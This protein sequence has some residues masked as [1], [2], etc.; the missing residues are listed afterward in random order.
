MCDTVVNTSAQCV[1][2]RSMQYLHIQLDIFPIRINSLP[3]VDTSLARLVVDVKVL[4]VVVEINTS[5]TQVSSEEGSV[6]GEDGRDVDVP[7]PAEGNG[8]T[9]LPF[10]EVGHDC[11][12]G[13]SASELR[14]SALVHI[15]VSE[16]GGSLTSPRNQ[17]TM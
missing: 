7:L 13:F 5:S 1:A 12:V 8:E 15:E 14:G 9:S 17:A 4:E 2:E 10:V 11:R 3:V 16:W 6:R